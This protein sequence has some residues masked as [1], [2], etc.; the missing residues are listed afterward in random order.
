M[1]QL[2]HR[3]FHDFRKLPTDQVRKYM[4]DG[5]MC[6]RG[7]ADQR[8]YEVLCVDFLFWVSKNLPF[9]VEWETE[10]VA[11]GPSAP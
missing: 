4:R 8:K 6:G 3:L 5:A 7:E 11:D 9:N 2:C 10:N 1:S